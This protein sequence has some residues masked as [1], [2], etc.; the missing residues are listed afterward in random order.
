MTEHRAIWNAVREAVF[1]ADIETGM[2]VHANPAAEALCGRT[3]AELRSLHYTQLH[4]PAV[5]KAARRGFAKDAKAPA[6]RQTTVLHKDGRRIPV[7]IAASHFTARNGRRMMIG[8]FRDIT[9]RYAAREDLRRSEERFRQ[10]AESAG[11]FIWEVDAAGLYVYASPVVRHILGYTPEE[12]VRKMRFYDLFPSE[13]REEMKKAAFDVFALRKPFHAFLNWNVTKDGRIVALETS[14]LPILDADGNFLGYRGADMDITERKRAEA[15]LAQYREHLEELVYQRT[16]ELESANAQL[17]RHIAERERAEEALRVSESR[18]REAERVGHTGFLDWHVPT[19]EIEWSDETCRIYGFEPGTVHP[20]LESTVGMA[21]PEDKRRVEQALARALS[22]AAEYDIE[23]RMVRPDGKVIHVHARAEV[24]RAADETPLRVFGT[25]VDITA[26]KEAEEALMRSEA[27]LRSIADLVPSRISYLDREQ[28]FRFANARCEEWFGCRREEIV[29]RH[30]K[31]VVGA[32]FY[33]RVRS[34]IEE[35]L[36]GSQVRYEL[37]ADEPG[38]RPRRHLSIVY[39]PHF[40]DCG[41]VLGFFCSIEDITERKHLEEQVRQAQKMEAVGVLAG[42]VAHD[43]NNL[44]TVINGY[45]QLA[46][47]R[48]GPGHPVSRSLEEIF[49]AGEQAASLTRQLLAF[50]RR[51]MLQPKV[52]DLNALLKDF[53]S[54]LRRLI[55]AHIDLRLDLDPALA[56]VKADPA[57]MQQV[58]M[59][60]VVNARD[61]MP[62][63]GALTIATRNARLDGT[64]SGV[65]DCNDSGVLPGDYVFLSVKDTGHGMDA[66]TQARIFEPFFTTKGV[67]RGTGLGLSTTYGIVKQSGG[68]ISVS[69]EPGRGSTFRICLPKTADSGE[70]QEQPA[71]SPVPEAPAATE[72]ILLV[73]DEPALRGMVRHALSE[74]GYTVLEAADGNAALELSARHPGAVHLLLTDVIMPR[75]GG[76]ELAGRLTGQRPEMR[77]LYISGYNETVIAGPDLRDQHAGFLQKPFAIDDLIQKVGKLLAAP[78]QEPE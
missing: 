47:A 66:E 25:I 42:G 40:G 23:H 20:T 7:E 2:I 71:D 59:N 3:L 62:D 37:D 51:Q 14:G 75:L 53:E 74:R 10:V 49:Q 15:E 19:G 70:E 48:L 56:R 50:S 52:L 4:P 61:A 32:P 73:E 18:L 29:G 41:E 12:L 13:T 5:A 43:F 24:T 1:L 33:E 34:H 77:V 76:R 21:P 57:Q 17:R 26:R 16:R 63:G 60:L 54:M 58:L 46:L 38:G 22:G 45:T 28:H 67:G 78:R 44:L 39:V 30:V 9:E 31:D 69:S 11:E 36:S 68:Y 72:T 65:N 27:F 55:E 64:E 6:L 8:V 35:A